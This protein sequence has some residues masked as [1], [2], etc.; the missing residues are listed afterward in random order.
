MDSCILINFDTAAAAAEMQPMS[1]DGGLSDVQTYMARFESMRN[2]VQGKRNRKVFV[3]HK[4]LERQCRN[5]LRSQEF[6]SRMNDAELRRQRDRIQVLEGDLIT[7]HTA[8]R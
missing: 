4:E 6:T 7:L 5:A 1:Y 2:S 8:Q 3:V